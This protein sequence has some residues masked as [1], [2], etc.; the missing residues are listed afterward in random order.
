MYVFAVMGTNNT[1]EYVMAFSRNKD[2]KYIIVKNVKQFVCIM[3][4]QLEST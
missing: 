3:I 4:V 1:D 2:L